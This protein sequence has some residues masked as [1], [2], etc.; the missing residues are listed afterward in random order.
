MGE[1]ITLPYNFEPRWYQADLMNCLEKYNRGVA[2]WHRR[3]GKDKTLINIV[4]MKAWERV[5]LYHYVFPY[6]AQGRKILWQGM[7]K[8][9]FRF[10]DHIPRALRKSTNKQEMMIE[11]IN[12]SIIQIVGS[13]DMDRIVGTNPVGIVFSEY[14]LQRPEA[15]GYYRPILLENDGWALFNYTP[16]GM[17]HGYELFKMAEKNERWFCQRWT[18]KDTGAIDEAAVERER[19]EEGMS[20]S[21]VRQEF[22]CS[23]EASATNQVI[24]FEVLSAAMERKH[25]PSVW[26]HNP[27]LIGVD[28]ARFGD[29]HSSICVRQGL[30]VLDMQKFFKLDTMELVDKVIRAIYNWKGYLIF[31]DSNGLGAGVADRLRQLRHRVIDVSAGS[32][33]SDDSRFLNLRAEMWFNTLE[34]LQDGGSLNWLM[35]NDP[36]LGRKRKELQTQLSAQTYEYTTSNKIKL[37]SKEKMK[38]DGIP[39]PDMA[40]ALAMTLAYKLPAWEVRPEERGP[41]RR[42]AR[43]NDP[44]TGV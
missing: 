9:G 13:D 15:W 8:T 33:A 26:Q 31:V 6:Y 40:D 11:L 20:D 1:T 18:I 17:N 7:D 12:G 10:L 32:R 44:V 30:Q 25:H 38:L 27:V 36:D 42:R 23:W 34:W 29:D 41:R 19:D 22:Y 14:S 37:T 3:A 2:V 28:V 24:P 4:A 5:G 39:S 35:A 43:I 16:R 21:L